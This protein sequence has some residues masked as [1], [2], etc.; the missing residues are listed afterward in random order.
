LRDVV[1]AIGPA[2]NIRP[3]LDRGTSLDRGFGLLDIHFFLAG[4]ADSPL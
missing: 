1:D 2:E 3:R 4:R